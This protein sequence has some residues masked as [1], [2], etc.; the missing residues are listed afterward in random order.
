MSRL[1]DAVFMVPSCLKINNAG[2][3]GK[4]KYCDIS[5]DSFDAVMGLNLRA[6]V[7]LSKLAIPYLKE[8][9]G[10]IIKK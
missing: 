9:K 4:G 6:A 2:R 8:S 7:Y 3:I 5:M 1:D 10:I